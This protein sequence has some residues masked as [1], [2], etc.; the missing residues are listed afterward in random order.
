MSDY[1]KLHEHLEKGSFELTYTVQACFIF[2]L[3]LGQLVALLAW[4]LIAGRARGEPSWWG[5]FAFVGYLLVVQAGLFVGW[6][7]LA[8]WWFTADRVFLADLVA[9]VHFGIAVVVLLVLALLP[10]AAWRGWGWARNFWLRLAHLL[11]V[12]IIAGQA[13]VG[14]VCP[15]TSLENDLR[16]WPDVP[17]G[18]KLHNL[19]GA[20]EWGRFC[21]RGI[22]IASDQSREFRT[23]SY[24]VVGVAVLLAWLL[25]PARL[26]W[27]DAPPNKADA[28]R[29]DATTSLAAKPPDDPDALRKQ[30]YHPSKT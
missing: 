15:L 16:P 12:E 4:R 2:Y 21:H 30:D 18:S 13:L 17:N 28:D 8:G 25:I 19:A 1:A 3:V 11:L 24:V 20:T 6:R 14:I 10:V 27:S 29:Q 5:R 26:P 23:G 7:S 22:F 9:T